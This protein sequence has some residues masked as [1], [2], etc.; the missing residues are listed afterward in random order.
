MTF[1]SFI[2]APKI[3]KY[4]GDP[5]QRKLTQGY[6]NT[7][8]CDIASGSPR[9]TVSWYFGWTTKDKKVDA[10]YDSRF[11]HPSDEEW[12]ITGIVV[13]DAGQYRCIVENSAGTDQLRF[14]IT[15]VEG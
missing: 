2:A 12:T 1:V 6:N 8:H 5:V 10:I 14:W 7:F 11:S 4:Q 13:G 15:A 3:N 9:P